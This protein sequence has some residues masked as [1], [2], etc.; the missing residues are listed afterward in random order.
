MIKIDLNVPL[1]DLEGKHSSDVEAL[2][3]NKLAANAMASGQEVDALKFFNWAQ[4]L[5]NGSVIEVDES[6]FGTIKRFFENHKTMYVIAKGQIL[7][8]LNACQLESIKD[9]K[10][11]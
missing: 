4:K 8:L 11:K 2:T 9:K 6:D 7:Q 5:Y 1:L 3:I 10:K